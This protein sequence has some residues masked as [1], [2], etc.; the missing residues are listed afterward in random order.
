M[1]NSCLIALF[2]SWQANSKPNIQPDQLGLHKQTKSD[3][4]PATS[5]TSS[6]EQACR[7]RKPIFSQ[8]ESSIFILPPPQDA[9]IK[10]LIKQITENIMKEWSTDTQV[11]FF[12]LS[13]SPTYET[14]RYVMALFNKCFGLKSVNNGIKFNINDSNHKHN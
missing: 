13:L 1:F 2:L 12:S 14:L 3:L 10:N 8:T 7:G 4:A 6:M 9:P 11:F 5:R